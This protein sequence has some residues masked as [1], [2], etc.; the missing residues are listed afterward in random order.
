MSERRFGYRV[1]LEM[2][3]NEYVEDRLHRCV[4]ANVSE[5]G[6]YLHGLLSNERKRR[7]VQLEFEL[8]GTGEVIWAAGQV[9]YKQVDPYFHGTGVRLTGITG[10]HARLMRDYVREKRKE[11]LN[12]L[13]KLIRQNR[14]H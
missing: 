7:N 4:T 1:P 3:L 12:E 9:A 14:Y 2:F 13:L 5:T 6:L 11:Q 8:P 10:V